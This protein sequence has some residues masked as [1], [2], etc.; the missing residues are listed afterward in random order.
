MS[1]NLELSPSARRSASATAA[2]DA[3]DR[4]CDGGSA[5]MPT[6]AVS[7]KWLRDDVNAVDHMAPRALGL[8]RR[9]TGECSDADVDA[10]HILPAQRFR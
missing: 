3:L 1:R 9:S 4:A 5:W 8:P 7:T 2:S 6:R 10:S